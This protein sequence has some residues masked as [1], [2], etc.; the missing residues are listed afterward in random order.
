[1]H[2]QFVLISEGSSDNGLISHLEAVCIHAGADAA[3]GV[4]LDR[5]QG[6][7]FGDGRE[8]DGRADRKLGQ[9]SLAAQEARPD[10]Q[11]AADAR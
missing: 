6:Q 1:M 2:V 7:P 9:Q 11:P 3:R 8:G 5:Q 4:A 10:D